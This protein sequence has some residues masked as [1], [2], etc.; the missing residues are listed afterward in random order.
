MSW[1]KSKFPPFQITLYLRG[2]PPSRSNFR[3]F[4]LIGCELYP[5]KSENKIP[6]SLDPPPVTFSQS[7][8]FRFCSSLVWF[9]FPLNT[10][11][12]LLPDPFPLFLLSHS[13]GKTQTLG[14]SDSAF[15]NLSLGCWR[16]SSWIL[17]RVCCVQPRVNLQLCL[18]TSSQ[19]WW[20]CFP[21][22][23]KDYF[24]SASFWRA[25]WSF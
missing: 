21:T 12:A 25:F 17:L 2:L 22:P 8:Y 15:Y 14:P 10:L 5:I 3:E 7:L 6:E 1:F 18:A 4:L 23:H 9:K 20:A 11:I 16:G 24:K 19:S 13:T